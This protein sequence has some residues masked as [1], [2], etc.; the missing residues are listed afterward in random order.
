MCKVVIPSVLYGAVEQHQILPGKRCQID[1]ATLP[2][3]HF[4]ACSLVPYGNDRPSCLTFC[5]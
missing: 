4:L 1:E 5:E 2:I 3:P